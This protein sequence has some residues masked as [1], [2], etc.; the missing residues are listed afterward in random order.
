MSGHDH[1]PR[2]VCGNCRFLG[3]TYQ[4]HQPWKCMRFG[5]KSKEIPASVVFRET[6]TECAL[7]EPRTQLPRG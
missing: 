7:Y 2:M 1:K 4:P 5:F 6:G 3:V